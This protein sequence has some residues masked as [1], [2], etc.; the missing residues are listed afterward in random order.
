M[1]KQKPK[2]AIDT[3]VKSQLD[4]LIQGD[5]KTYEQAITSLISR[6]PQ[7]IYSVLQNAVSTPSIGAG[8]G[9]E[10]FNAYTRTL[11]WVKDTQSKMPNNYRDE[12]GNEVYQ[13]SPAQREEAFNIDPFVRGIIAPYL[14]NI[15]LGSDNI[16]TKDNKLYWEAIE[17]IK[18]F[19]HDINYLEICH[20][21][22][23]DYA[24]KHGKSYWRKEYNGKVLNRI[25]ILKAGA[26]YTYI[27]PW[28]SSIK[29]YHQRIYINTSFD[30]DYKAQTEYNTWWI[31][32][33]ILIIDG[34]TPENDPARTIWNQ[35][36]K[37][38]NISK[39]ANLRVGNSEDIICM[40]LNEPNSPAP[41]DSILV[42]IYLKRL[43]LANSPNL[44][45]NALIPFIHMKK[46]LA[47][48]SVN[49]QTGLKE[50][51]TSI[52]QMPPIS[53]A[54]TDPE[55][56]A[57]LKSVYD[58]FIASKLTDAENI[59]KYRAGNGVFVTGPDVSLE[60]KQSANTITSSFVN[61]MLGVLDKSIGYGLGFPDALV[62]ATGS[63]LA[64]TRTIKEQF[65]AVF[66]GIKQK[67]Q[68]IAEDLIF[69]R[70]E[71]HSWTYE[72]KDRENNIIETGDYT[73]EE[74]DLHYVLGEQDKKD[75]LIQ[76]QTE[77]VTFQTIQIAKIIGASKSDIQAYLDEKEDMG[78]WELDNYDTAI[79]MLEQ[80]QELQEEGSEL[81][82]IPEL[83][84]IEIKTPGTPPPKTNK[85]EKSV[86]PQLPLDVRKQSA[87]EMIETESTVSPKQNKDQELKPATIPNKYDEKL[88]DD[89]MTVYKIAE[90][91]L[92]ELFSKKG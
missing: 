86:T 46:G 85:P 30:E 76:A 75:A 80:K 57:A 15:I 39:T 62:N 16:I 14:R 42:E 11:N 40:M 50:L 71:G 23:A 38:Y 52:P 21:S 43:V 64:T 82:A 84:P 24:I 18:E 8:E 87:I 1:S 77:L 56:Y 37:K 61:T 2:I 10:V 66:A 58:N 92:K 29:L 27:D 7:E 3:S 22:F 74:I 54:T 51:I 59:V 5:I 65:N 17:D 34:V 25:Q 73:L 90:E 67:Y 33:D 60:I 6:N 36:V 4:G 45:F 41:I 35:Y 44:I 72:I 31:P 63:E 53:M 47:L 19:L 20:K 69:E 89:F 68:R 12:Y 81:P 55:R 28:D 13:V 88:I 26:T 79:K 91:E 83:K 32:E 70:F 9:T 78:L 48:E 49:P